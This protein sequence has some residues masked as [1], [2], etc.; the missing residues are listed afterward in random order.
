MKKETGSFVLKNTTKKFT[1]NKSP[2]NLASFVG[3]SPQ[4]AEFHVESGVMLQSPHNVK[5][6]PFDR[7]NFI[8]S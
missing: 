6:K 3:Q 1:K 2:T 4:Y 5:D 7:I 8:R